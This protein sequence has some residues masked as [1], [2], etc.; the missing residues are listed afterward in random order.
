MCYHSTVTFKIRDRRFIEVLG[1]SRHVNRR[2]PFNE[3]IFQRKV[4]PYKLTK[5]FIMI[6]QHVEH[7]RPLEF[8]QVSKGLEWIVYRVSWTWQY[9]D[10]ASATITSTIVTSR[11]KPPWWA[12]NLALYGIKILFKN[13]DSFAWINKLLSSLS[14]EW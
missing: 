14:T 10:N 8:S 6:I 3:Q 7:M 12:T 13:S 1:F 11:A 5:H 2:T 4:T 9:Y